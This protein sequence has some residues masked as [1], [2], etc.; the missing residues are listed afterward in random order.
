MPTRQW[1]KIGVDLFELEGKDYLIIVDYLS[2]F[3]EIDR[4]RDTTATTVIKTMKTH[5]ARYGI[6]STVVSDKGPQFTSSQFERFAVDYDF[7]HNTSDPYHHQSNG[8][9]E[10]AVKTAKNILKKNKDGDQFLALLNYRNTP[11]QNSN[12]SP[13]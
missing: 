13:A 5:I 2:N 12:T 4:L 3:W 9:V 7:E 6:P 10:S 11:S 8:K 1:E